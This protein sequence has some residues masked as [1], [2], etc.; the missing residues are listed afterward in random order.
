MPLTLNRTE[1]GCISPAMSSWGKLRH[2]CMVDL[3]AHMVGMGRHG[4]CF[5]L[6]EGHGGRYRC[7]AEWLLCMDRLPFCPDLVLLEGKEQGLGGQAYGINKEARMHLVVVTFTT[8]FALVDRVASKIRQHDRLCRCPADAGRSNV[9][10]HLLVVGHTSVMG[11]DNVQALLELGVP[12]S[13]V[14]LALEAIAVMAMSCPWAAN[15]HA[16]CSRPTGADRRTSLS[17]IQSNPAAVHFQKSL[18]GTG[19]SPP[20]CLLHMAA[21]RPPS[22]VPSVDARRPARQKSPQHGAAKKRQQSPDCATLPMRA[23]MLKN[24]LPEDPSFSTTASPP[25]C[26]LCPLK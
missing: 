11:L 1:G 25:A 2:G 6:H 21:R 24:S 5:M 15:M 7:F 19:G 3:I 12:P 26:D 14:Q 23:R 22:R 4:D 17:P 8:D 13:R 18:S 9:E 10:L 16:R 20:P